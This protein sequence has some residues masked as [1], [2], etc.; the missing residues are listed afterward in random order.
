MMSQT[1][2]SSPILIVGAGGMV[3]SAL[4]SLLGTRAVPLTRAQCDITDVDG[5]SRFIAQTRPVAVI[6]CAA[7]TNVDLCEQDPALADAVNTIAV[8]QLANLCKA[9]SCTLIHFSTDYVFDGEGSTPWSEADPRH[10]INVYGASKA[11]S[12]EAIESSPTDYIIARVQWVFGR[13]RRNFIQ[14]TAAKLQAGQEVLAFE[15]QWGGPGFSRDIARMI[16][17]LYEG[18]HRGLFHVTNSGYDSR[19]GIAHE[20][21]RQMKIASPHIT[22]V[23]MKSLSLPAVRSQNSRLSVDKL[24]GLGIIPPSWQDAVHRYLIEEDFIPHD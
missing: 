3:G 10:P 15:D 8:S 6:N 21:A 23:Q 9:N 18:G 13:G 1:P 22:A 7:I 17:E 11:R 19:L 16:V 14:D 12:E 24:K 4:T 20:I 5:V 2:S